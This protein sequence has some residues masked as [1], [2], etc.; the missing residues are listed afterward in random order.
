MRIRKMVAGMM[1]AC[2]LFQMPQMQALT[3][4]AVESDGGTADIQ[5]QGKVLKNNMS[6][7][8]VVYDGKDGT[9]LENA[10][11]ALDSWSNYALTNKTG[12]VTLTGLVEQQKYDVYVGCGGYESEIVEYTCIED[13]VEI[14]VYLPLDKSGG[15]GGGP[16]GGGSGT[17]GPSTGKGPG[18]DTSE[19]QPGGITPGDTGENIPGQDDTTITPGQPTTGNQNPAGTQPGEDDQNTEPTDENNQ[20]EDNQPESPGGIETNPAMPESGD[21]VWIRITEDE[22]NNSIDSGESLTIEAGEEGVD[23]LK[24]G[25]F[26]EHDKGLLGDNELWTRYT[27]EDGWSLIVINEEPKTE[28]LVVR[29]AQIPHSVMDTAKSK[30]A[31]V[32]VI[33][34]EGDQDGAAAIFPAGFFEK[35][36]TEGKDLS[37][38][39]DKETGAMTM[40]YSLPG[41]HSDAG[42]LVISEN[43][44][45]FAGEKGFNLKS[46][47]YNPSDDE[48]LW[49]EWHFTSE[50]LKQVEAVD[51]DLYIHNDSQD[52]ENAENALSSLARWRRVQLFSINYHGPLPAPASLRVK[53][54]AG[55]PEEK[56]V[57]YQTYNT[58]LGKPETLYTNVGFDSEGFAVIPR[59]EHCSSYALAG[60]I[61]WWWLAAGAA[62]IAAVLALLYYMLKQKK[63]RSAIMNEVWVESQEEE[64]TGGIVEEGVQSEPMAPV[65]QIEQSEEGK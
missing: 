24:T 37:V 9:L 31:D 10:T 52:I 46:K 17:N 18:I 41:A 14:E 60:A 16:G 11:V 48:D 36:D 26:S 54:L 3:Y 65:E 27:E 12:K 15:S 7:T 49:Y 42:S 43:A 62:G 19:S 59:M 30:K 55:F 5:L 28:T 6:V 25:V 38:E 39:Y 40:T 64:S 63:K 53:N 21:G 35:E 57:S 61:W 32:Q 1:M 45:A 50:D 4:G 58:D 44:F 20:D 51:T 29:Q 47:I 33:F 22:I 23:P 8:V 34:R 13:N 56:T 2:L